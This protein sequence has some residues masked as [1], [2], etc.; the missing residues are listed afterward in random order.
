MTAELI[1]KNVKAK[2]KSEK[3]TQ[4]ELASKID[5]LTYDNLYQQIHYNRLPDAIE[6]YQ[7]AKSLKTTV[8]ALIT[9]KD[10]PELSNSEQ[11]LIKDFRKLDARDQA[12]ILDN[13]QGKIERAKKGD[14]RLK[15]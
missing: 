11:E 14:I 1:W 5:G 2:I 3:T 13:I 12:D 15:H 7:I 10:G 4:K 9:G 8:E 6:L